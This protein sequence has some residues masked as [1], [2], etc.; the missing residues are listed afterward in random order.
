MTAEQLKA[1]QAPLKQQYGR[2]PVKFLRWPTIK[3]LKQK[4]VKKA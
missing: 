4:M 3:Y 1:L 2:T